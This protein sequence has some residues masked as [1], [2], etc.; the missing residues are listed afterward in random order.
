MLISKDSYTA[1]C[2]VHHILSDGS[3][4]PF[5]TMD[6]SASSLVDLLDRVYLYVGRPVTHEG[7]NAIQLTGDVYIKNKMPHRYL[8]HKETVVLTINVTKERFD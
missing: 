8:N 6:V 1:H 7:V 4:R 3:A 5:E 2:T